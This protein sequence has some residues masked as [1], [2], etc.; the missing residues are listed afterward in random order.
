YRSIRAWEEE[1]LMQHMHASPFESLPLLRVFSFCIREIR[2][3]RAISL[4]LV[5]GLMHNAAAQTTGSR[6]P[7]LQSETAGKSQRYRP[8]RYATEYPG[9]DIGA[10][11]AAAFLDCNNAC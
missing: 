10:Q 6:P 5:C 4:F 11:V 2:S 8:A 9:S 7:I 1:R 3:S